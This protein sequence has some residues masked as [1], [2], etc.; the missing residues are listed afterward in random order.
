MKSIA[1]S[2]DSDRSEK[3]T[4]IAERAQTEAQ[5]VYIAGRTFQVEPRK[6]S[7]S[8]IAMGLLNAAIDDA[9]AQL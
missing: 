3:L 7:A 6:L 2:L 9:H 1:I 4:K 5:S 8:A